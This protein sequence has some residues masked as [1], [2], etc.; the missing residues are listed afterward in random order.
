MG[1][2]QEQ[3]LI[4]MWSWWLTYETTMAIKTIYKIIAYVQPVDKDTIGLQNFIMTVV[5][6]DDWGVY[7]GGLYSWIFLT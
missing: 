6:T 5:R 1:F 7:R 2:F 4:C 3:Y